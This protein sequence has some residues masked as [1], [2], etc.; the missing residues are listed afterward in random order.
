MQIDQV[1]V[2][3][4]VSVFRKVSN[5][6]IVCVIMMVV[7]G[8]L[9]YVLFSQPRETELEKQIAKISIDTHLEKN[10]NRV[11][12]LR[13]DRRKCISLT[14][15]LAYDL[16]EWESFCYATIFDEFS[17]LYKT[18]WELYAALI[19]VETNFNP[20]R[21]SGK[22]CKGLMQI[23]ESTGK[24]VAKKLDIK[25]REGQSLWNEFINIAIGS[26]YLSDFVNKRGVH[27]GIKSYLG[28]PDYK[29]SVQKKA[30]T[31][32]YVGEYKTRVSEEYDQLRYMF[33]GIVDEHSITDFDE[34]NNSILL[35][36]AALIFD[37][38]EVETTDSIKK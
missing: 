38:F 7:G 30:E 26:T 11:Y 36:T 5:W 9:F 29:K 15:Q 8:I 4:N 16:S 20:T 25:F 2:N 35:D 27:G 21:K 22:D 6:F 10:K 37:I 24:E 18:H 34:M 3:E 13:D 31:F 33:R 14:L 19:R 17:L 1:D 28:G 23:K 32:K 12:L